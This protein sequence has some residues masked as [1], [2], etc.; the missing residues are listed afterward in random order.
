MRYKVLLALAVLVI[1]STIAKGQQSVII[2]ATTISTPVGWASDGAQVVI[3]GVTGQRIYVTAFDGVAS[4][5]GTVLLTS[6]TGA[7]CATG[8]VNITGTY[9][10][11]TQT[12]ISIGTGN[13]AIWVVGSGLNLCATV[14]SP[15]GLR[16]FMSYSIF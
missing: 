5:T 9:S 8:T 1:G 15:V 11:T 13:G 14:T 12:R 10:L 4:G 2:P 7:G 3:S 16:G 6:G